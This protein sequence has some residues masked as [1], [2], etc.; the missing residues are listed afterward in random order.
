M[1]LTPGGTNAAFLFTSG[2]GGPF[3]PIT[4]GF[5]AGSNTLTI[6]VN[7]TTAGISGGLSGGVNCG[8][9]ECRVPTSVSLSAELMYNTAPVPLPAGLPLLGVSLLAIGLRAKR[10]RAAAI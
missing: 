3:L 10:R 9:A 4:T 2:P 7:D 5:V 8:F 6:I 1:V